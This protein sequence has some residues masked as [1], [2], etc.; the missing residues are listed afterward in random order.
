[1][2]LYKYLRPERIDVLQN[3]KIRYTQACALNDPF[4]SFP[5]I[6]QKDKEWYKRQFLKRI[7]SEADRYSFSNAVKRKQFIRARK[8]E[9]DNFYRCYTDEEWL[10]EQTQSVIL[11]D[12]AI[13]GYLSLSATNK[14][15][16]MWSHYAQ[17]HEGFVVGFDKKHRYFDYGLMKVEYKDERPFLDPTQPKQD[18][19]LFYTK[20]TDWEYEEEYRKSIGFVDSI[21]LENGNTLLPFPEETPSKN[22]PSLY[23]IKLFDFPK[24]CISSIIVGWKSAPGLRERI[25][26]QLEKHGVGSVKMYKAFPH[27]FKYEMVVQ[28]IHE[29]NK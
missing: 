29:L 22:D 3:L 27:K 18:A 25:R 2:E 1:M 10:F 11:L 20:S 21:Q 13:E 23:E 6:I 26:E 8:R 12:S 7:E 19:G 9:F 4:E 17:N 15:I 28:E 24:E 14:N 16:L 5:A